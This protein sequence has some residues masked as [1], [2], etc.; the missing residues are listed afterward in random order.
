MLPLD[1][2]LGKMLII[3]TLFGC[4]DSALTVAACLTSKPIFVSPM[5]KRDEAN[6]YAHHLYTEHY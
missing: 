3:G 1:L 5:E 6:L 2:R 4:L